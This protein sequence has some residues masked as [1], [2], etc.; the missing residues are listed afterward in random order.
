[1]QQRGE[2]SGLGGMIHDAF[3]HRSGRM[4]AFARAVLAV[5]FLLAIWVDRS[6]PVQLPRE[7]YFLLVAYALAAIVLCRLI[8]NDWRLEWRLAV[9]SHIL[10]LLVFA[11]LNYATEGYTSPFFTFFV[12]LILSASVRWGWRGTAVTAAAIV[13][14]Y[15][16]AGLS[17]A[18]WG[19][20]RFDVQRFAIRSGYLVALSSIIVLWFVINRPREVTAERPSRPDRPGAIYARPILA[21]AIE[22][23]AAGRAVMAWWESEEPWTHVARLDGDVLEEDRLDPECYEPLTAPALG[24]DVLLF[25]QKRGLVLRR[26]GRTGKTMAAVRDPIH[27]DFAADFDIAEGLRIA[28]NA[29]ACRAEILVLDIPGLCPDDLDLAEGAAVE[30][31]AR[32]ER[33]ALFAATDEAAAMQARLALAR[34]LHDSTVQFLAGLSLRLEGVRKTA[35]AGGDTNAEVEALQRELTA[36]QRE[37]RRFIHELRGNRDARARADL[38]ASLKALLKRIGS[39]W[40]VACSFDCRPGEIAVPPPLERNVHQLAREA[41]ANAVRHGS[42]SAITTRLA[43]VNGTIELEISDNG[44]GFPVHGEFDDEEMAARRIGPRS[45]TERVHSLGGSLRLATGAEGS[46]LSIALPLRAGES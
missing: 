20:E 12:F 43:R 24:G 35:A 21:Y 6:Q 19:T 27:P 9:P 4:I 18:S 44:G 39:Q 32:I 28:V 42:A 3:Q 30:I 38:A 45:L 15:V 1:M 16:E 34:D 7:T 13:A 29:G 5:F 2:R 37:F 26:R 10:D 11:C 22:H 41:V 36:E 23:F 46:R 25:D 31:A 8:W 17:A 40:N 14:L 33:A